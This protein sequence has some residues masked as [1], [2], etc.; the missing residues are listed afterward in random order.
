MKRTAL[1][2]ALALAVALPFS[3]QAATPG[4]NFITT[5]DYDGNG[6]VTLAEV[7]ERRADLFSSFDENEDGVLSAAELAAHDAMRDQMQQQ[8]RLGWSDDTRPAQQL[9]QGFGRGPGALQQQG[10]GQGGR[11]AQRGP[12]GGFSH[13]PGLQQQGFGGG[14]GAMRGAQGQGQQM[15]GIGLDADRDGSV[16]RDEFVNLGRQWFARFDRDGDGVVLPTDFGTGRRW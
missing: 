13:G 16:S 12:Q 5:W 2:S 1:I 15:A 3:A 8:D 9:G 14:P 10:A 7:L 11:L 4:E 6:Q